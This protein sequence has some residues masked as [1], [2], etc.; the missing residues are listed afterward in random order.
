VPSSAPADA[1][2]G[3]RRLDEGPLLPTPRTLG[4]GPWRGPLGYSAAFHA[5][6]AV[7]P[8]RPVIASLLERN[9]AS[10]GRAERAGLTQ[11]WRGPDAGNPD[12]AAVRL[13]LADRPL[14][15]DL[16]GAITAHP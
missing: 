13:V 8:D 3:W 16:L 1:P 10:C 11:V 9:L 12:P 5:A 14:A 7:A 15:T 2:S 4:A 6:R